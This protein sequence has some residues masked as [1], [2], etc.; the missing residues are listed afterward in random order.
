MPRSGPLPTSLAQ[1]R[2]WFLSQFEGVGTAYHLCGRLRLE[3]ALDRG[4][5]GRALARIVERHEALRTRFARLDGQ[6]V[7]VID[8]GDR[9]LALR[10]TISGKARRARRSSRPSSKTNRRRGSISSTD[11]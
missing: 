11:R 9:G 7:M 3:G 5:L 10:S 8:P 2:L 6:P 4:A 1:Q